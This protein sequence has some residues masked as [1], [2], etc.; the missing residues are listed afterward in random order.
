MSL[1]PLKALR[2]F[3]AVARLGSFAAAAEAL[4]VTQSAISHQ[5]RH[6]E[7]WLGAPLFDRRGPRPRLLPRGTDLARDLTLALGGIDAACDRARMH[8]P[9]SALVVAAI[10]SV[11]VCWLIPRLPA[12]RAAHRDIPLRVIYSLHGR[13][14]D[15]RDVHVAFTFASQT[16]R[17]PG[18]RAVPFL[19]GDS[20][21]VC[22]P[23]YAERL[24]CPDPPPASFLDAELLHDSDTSHWAAWL[25]QAGVATARPLDG[26]VFEDFNLL[27][28]AALSG[29]GIA[30]CP[31][32]MIRDDL[33]QGSLIRLSDITV[34]QDYGYYLLSAATGDDAAGRMAAAFCDWALAARQ[35]DTAG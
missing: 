14:I 8:A 7:D 12:F 35:P 11:A 30:L 15:F 27:R 2:A 22:S 3:E 6:L 29:Q 17:H 21:P 5:V 25:A 16:P 9:P 26:P 10:P 1:P 23:A 32:A 18:V 20:F 13:D 4:F 31:T 28:A 24:N 34:R 19:P 33:A